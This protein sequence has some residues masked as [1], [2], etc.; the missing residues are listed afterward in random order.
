MK[1]TFLATPALLT[2]ALAA[3]PA[4]AGNI[5]EPIIT[6]APAPMAAP[7]IIDTGSDWTGFYAGG[8]LGYA[9]VSDTTAAFDADGATYGIHGGYDYDFGS[10]IL[11]G[12]LEFSGFDV[13]DGANSISSVAR[14]KLRAGYDAGAFMPYIT[15]G[16]AEVDVDGLDVTDTGAVYGL[17][18][19]YSYND[20]VRIGGEILQHEF[21]D[22]GGLDVDATTAA[23]RVSFDF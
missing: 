14:A 19:D 1:R 16:V 10:F 17:G 20:R 18:L 13:E 12:E 22:V 6:P 21:D 2:L 3:G 9:D 5:D 4:L 8:S 23:V 7:V 11:G 15:A